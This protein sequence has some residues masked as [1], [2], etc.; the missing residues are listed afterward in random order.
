[1]DVCACDIQC[2]IALREI[3]LFEVYPGIVMGPYQAAFKTKQLVEMGVTHILNVTCREYTKRSK[4]F[5]YLDVQLYDTH[6]EYSKKHYRIT[7]RFIDE[8]RKKG[9]KVLVQSV[10]G[11]SRAATFILAYLIGR[12]KL[13]LKDGLA[14]LRQYVPEVEPNESFM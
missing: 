1:M 8:A 2:Q 10:Q 4:Y 6:S 12:E 7:N 5:K 3:N 13:K 11:K 9:N 14:M